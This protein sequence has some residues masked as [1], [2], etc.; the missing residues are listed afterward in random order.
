MLY[1][2]FSSLIIAFSKLDQKFEL[3]KKVL[4]VFKNARIGYYKCRVDYEKNVMRK[5]IL[6][7]IGLIV[8]AFTVQGKVDPPNY[9]FSLDKFLIFMPGSNLKDIE[10]KYKNKKAVFSSDEFATYKFQIVHVRYK[11]PIFVQFKKGIVTDF[12][13]KL[14]SYF[15]HNI[16]HQSLINRYGKQDSFNNANEQSVYIWNNKKDRKH[17]Y[18][19]ACTITCFPLYYAVLPVKN[20]HGDEY[21]SVFNKLIN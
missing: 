5:N 20:V 8:S 21:K 11:F 17:V 6:L 3:S 12:H 18:S 13:A 14:P 16:F 15:L 2:S 4:P 10:K 1:F 7:S 19:G 9:D